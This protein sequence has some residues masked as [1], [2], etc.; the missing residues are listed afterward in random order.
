MN[1]LQGIVVRLNEIV[2]M[3]GK[4][5]L[6]LLGSYI[7]GALIVDDVADKLCETSE[8]LSRIADLGSDL[9]VSTDGDEWMQKDWQEVRLLV[10]KLSIKS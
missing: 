6:D 7:V 3:E 5:P 1:T 8:T 4:E 10:D 2:A 9:E